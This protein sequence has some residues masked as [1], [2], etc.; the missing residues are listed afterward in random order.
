MASSS[1]AAFN[2]MMSEA[3]SSSQLFSAEQAF[4]N[5]EFWGLG[6]LRRPITPDMHQVINQILNCPYSGRIRR[7]YLERK[8]LE[9]V[10]LKLTVLDPSRSL[11]CPLNSGDLDG[12]YQAAKI[13]TCHCQNP[14]SIEVLARQVGL[15]RL[16]LNQGFHRVYGTTPYRYLRNRRLELANHLLSTSELAVEEVAYRVGYTNRSRFA[17][18]F[19]Q[20]FGLNPKTF[21]IQVGNAS[22]QP[23]RAS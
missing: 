19:R 9:L 18:A 3:D 2:Q 8:A 20:Q 15:N 5:L 23:N 6:N 21:Q 4:E 7:S 10:A 11:S 16:K 13:L 17:T 14:P 1:Q 22:H 12:I